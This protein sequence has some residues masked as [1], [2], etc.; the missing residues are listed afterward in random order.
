MMA[1]YEGFR[2]MT[3]TVFKK[4][5]RLHCSLT[6]TSKIDSIFYKANFSPP[7]ISGRNAYVTDYLCDVQKL[8]FC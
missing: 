1:L 8:F 2:E 4:V 5:L 6:D 3:D 7:A